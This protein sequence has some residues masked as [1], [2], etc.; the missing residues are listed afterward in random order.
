MQAPYMTPVTCLRPFGVGDAFKSKT[1]GRVFI[2]NQQNTGRQHW[3]L[4][5]P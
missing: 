5:T 3:K 1:W 2:D 4:P